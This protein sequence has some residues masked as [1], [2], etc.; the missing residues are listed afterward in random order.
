MSQDTITWWYVVPK[1]YIMY[2]CCSYEWAIWGNLCKHQIILLTTDILE[3]TF[4]EFYG[5]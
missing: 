3:S 4:L 1:P 2:A 5:T